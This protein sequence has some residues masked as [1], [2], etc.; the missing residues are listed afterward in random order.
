MF[1]ITIHAVG[2]PIPRG[3]AQAIAQALTGYL[4]SLGGAVH[5]SHR[6]DAAAFKE[7][8][9]ES[10]LM[11]FDTAP[12]QLLAIAG[13]RLSARLPARVRAIPARAGRIQDRLRAFRAGSVARAGMPARHH[14]AS[15]RNVRGDCRVGIRRGA[16]PMRGAALRA[17]RPAYALRSHARARG[18]TCAVGVLPRAQR[19]DDSI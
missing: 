5:T 1:G 19:V 4:Q 13:D 12:R 3:G 8:E 14:R 7:L 6:I 17:G 16:G 2:W 11:L 9:A 10:E 18:Q 15:G